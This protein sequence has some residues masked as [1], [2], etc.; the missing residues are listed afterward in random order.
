[1]DSKAVRALDPITVLHH[2]F[3][4]APREMPSPYQVMQCSVG[5]YCRWIDSHA[6]RDVLSAIQVY[7]ILDASSRAPQIGQ[8][9]RWTCGFPRQMRKIYNLHL[10]GVK[11]N[12]HVQQFLSVG[13]WHEL[14]VWCWYGSSCLFYHIYHKLIISYL[15]AGLRGSLQERSD[16][17]AGKGVRAHLSFYDSHFEA[18]GR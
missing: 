4:R 11:M 2:C 3:S 5:Q 16:Q 6:A 10:I 9:R 13:C 1:V 17:Q 18:S 7:F 14:L 8:G 12:V 15:A